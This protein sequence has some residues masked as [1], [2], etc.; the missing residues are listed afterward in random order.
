MNTI[1]CRLLD[2]QIEDCLSNPGGCF[3]IREEIMDN[4]A[5]TFPLNYN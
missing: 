2:N 3:K 4:G 1:K 5:K